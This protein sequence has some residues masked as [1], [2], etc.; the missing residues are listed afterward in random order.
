MRARGGDLERPAC[1]RL[2]AHVAEVVASERHQQLRARRHGE[3]RLLAAKR[4]HQLGERARN[5][6]L[7]PIHERGLALV[8]CRDEGARNAPLLCPQ[9]MGNQAA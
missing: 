1:G 7:D 5:P 2:P 8:R 6:D 3:Q 9:Q 4:G